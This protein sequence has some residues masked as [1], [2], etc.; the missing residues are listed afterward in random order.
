MTNRHDNDTSELPRRRDIAAGAVLSA[1]ALA[2]EIWLWGDEGLQTAVGAFGWALIA[3]YVVTTRLIDPATRRREILRE[4]AQERARNTGTWV[5]VSD[6][7]ETRVFGVW[8][9]PGRGWFSR[10]RYY[11]DNWSPEE[12]W[13]DAEELACVVITHEEAGF[14]PADDE[15]T[16]AVRARLDIP[17]WDLRPGDDGEH[18]L[19]AE[20]REGTHPLGGPMGDL[21]DEPARDLTAYRNRFK[22]GP[23]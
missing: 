1:V 16:R 17:G 7:G 12:H 10:F 3:G 2:V 13:R 23:Y 5:W 4:W 19:V 8:F 20:I 18:P 22:P 15:G 9:E 11:E 21:W 14:I 6:T